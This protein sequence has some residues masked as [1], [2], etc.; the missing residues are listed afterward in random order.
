MYSSFSYGWL[1]LG[2]LGLGLLAW[3][4]PIISLIRKHKRNYKRFNISTLVSLGS[5]SLSLWFQILYNHHLVEIKDWSALMDTTGA[6]VL[7]SGVLVIVTII[8]NII[9]IYSNRSR[10]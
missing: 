2:S 6:L 3:I 7:V 5:C 10:Y 9:S 8:L 1:N 4:I